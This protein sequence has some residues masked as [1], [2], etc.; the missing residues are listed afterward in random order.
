MNAKRI[1]ATTAGIMDSLLP[2]FSGWPA[3]CLS[4][5]SP[6]GG[7]FIFAAEVRASINEPA[8]ETV[9][10]VFT[11]KRLIRAPPI[12][13]PIMVAEPLKG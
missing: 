6:F 2:W 13:G 3:S 1:I 12:M 11:P 8:A 9:K 4:F 7:S 5:R 10:G